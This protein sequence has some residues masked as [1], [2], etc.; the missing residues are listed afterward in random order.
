MFIVL[1]FATIL[2]VMAFIPQLPVTEVHILS[3]IPHPIVRVS[4][5]VKS[6]LPVTDVRRLS[7]TPHPIVPRPVEH[8][9][10]SRGTED[11]P[12]LSDDD[13]HK[14]DSPK[15]DERPGP[16]AHDD[17]LEEEPLSPYHGPYPADSIHKVIISRPVE[18]LQGTKDHNLFFESWLVQGR[19]SYGGR[20]ANLSPFY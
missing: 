20:T 10:S 19:Q 3:P 1:W 16:A 5:P 12:L 15:A 6:L 11:D 13:S 17:G 9:D 18:S 8:L 14:A 4:Q 7:P 2:V